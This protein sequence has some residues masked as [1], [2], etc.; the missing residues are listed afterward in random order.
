MSSYVNFWVKNQKGQVTR[1]FSYSRSNMIYRVANDCN[2]WNDQGYASPLTID[3]VADMRGELETRKRQ[4]EKQ[5]CNYKT[6]IETVKDFK[7]ITLEEKMS[8]IEEYWNLIEECQEEI[9][10]ITFA[11]DILIL[12]EE[13]RSNNSDWNASREERDN[14]IWAGI[15]CGMK[16]EEEND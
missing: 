12:L 10:E 8:A 14:V 4:E 9:E 2:I 5:I 15:D 6:S 7:D 1:L 13:I 3:R 11:V 16:G